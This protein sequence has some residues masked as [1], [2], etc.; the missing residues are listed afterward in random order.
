MRNKTQNALIILGLSVST[1]LIVGITI[2]A[3]VNIQ[4]K[5]SGT[6]RELGQ[7]LSTTLATESADILN[8]L[9][10]SEQNG[11]LK[12]RAVSILSG[13]KDIAFL[14]YFDKDGNL[15]YSS[16]DDFAE[17]A[18]NKG[19]PN[20]LISSPILYSNPETG[21]VTT[22]GSVNLGLSNDAI[23]TV[24]K[25]TKNS[26]F[27][28]IFIT[29]SIYI[30]AILL[31]SY[32]ITRELNILRSGVRRIST[33]D[34]GY[35]IPS[36]TANGEI[37]ELF[38]A[39]NDMS[40]RLHQYEE[41]NVDKLTM[42]RNKFETVLMS[43]ANGVVVCDNFDTVVLVNNAAKKMLAV[44][45]EDIVNTKLQQFCDTNGQLCFKE[46]IE[47]F[48]DTPLDDMEKKPLE[49]N[50]EIDKT[51]LKAFMSPMLAKSQ[52]YAGYII[53]LIDVTREVEVD[54]LK[55]SFI[56][57][58]SHELRTP[59]T[60]LRTYIDTLY[61]H[62]DN[63]DAETKVEFLN[64]INTEAARLH[65]MV[66]DILDFS[67]L[68]AKD[69]KLHKEPVAIT[70]LIEAAVQSVEVLAKEKNITFSII[71]EPDLPEVT[72]NVDSIDSVLRN[73]LSNAI[74]YSNNGGKIKVRAEVAKDNRYVE[75]SV[76][77][78][79]MGIAPEYQKKV[80]D[81]FFRVENATHTIK[82]TGLGL[83][84]VKVAIEQHHQ[85]EVFVHSQLGEGSTFG[86]RIPFV[87]QPAEEEYPTGNSPV[88]AV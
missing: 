69:V 34:F 41:K 58:V 82:G 81:R 68:E 86:F 37:K 76:E 79:G 27:I 24:S 26:L 3:I 38:D 10:E 19:E 22:V 28:I 23:H 45:N 47:Q 67:R 57:N 83:H 54:K 13:N 40:A 52:E 49:F 17:R 84:L 36:S 60:V 88:K 85:G 87:P 77:D 5:L 9:P 20:T 16:S 2:V 53:V 64:V 18:K 32:L 63:F 1:F 30:I 11:A 61:N 14:E 73:L 66:N 44:E 46:K 70:N 59:V 42:E 7:V 56:S 29:W 12:N 43:I 35:K 74:K 21:E 55:N 31:N 78:N 15:K 33:G 65:K 71:K 25:A 75:V 39:F 62:A 48:K 80:F 50:I 8:S 72:L 4:G 51:V 6:Y